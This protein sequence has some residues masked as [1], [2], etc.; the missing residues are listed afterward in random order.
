MHSCY[1]VVGATGGWQKVRNRSDVDRCRGFA[2]KDAKLKTESP[3]RGGGGRSSYVSR[4]TDRRGSHAEIF[5]WAS[6]LQE[7]ARTDSRVVS[8]TATGNRSIYFPRPGAVKSLGFSMRDRRAGSGAFPQN[9]RKLFRQ[10]LP[11]RGVVKSLETFM[12]DRRAGSGSFPQNCRKLFRAAASYRGVVKSLKTFMRDRRASAKTGARY[13][14]GIVFS[15]I[16]VAD[17]ARKIRREIQVGGG[18]RTTTTLR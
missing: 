1:Q 3:R 15:R 14:R 11:A 18:R 9:C 10:R 13:S 5:F 7:G 2:R 12:R 4:S 8:T 6:E 17:G 16:E